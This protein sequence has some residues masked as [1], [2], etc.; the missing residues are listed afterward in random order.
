MMS[1]HGGGWLTPLCLQERC[2][3]LFRGN[4]TIW[5]AVCYYD[6]ASCPSENR[7]QTGCKMMAVFLGGR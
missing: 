3:K 2:F 7:R 1:L 4:Y 5:A 6:C